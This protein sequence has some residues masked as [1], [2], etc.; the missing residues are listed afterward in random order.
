[1]S[2]APASGVYVIEVCLCE[3]A[4]ISVGRLGALRFPAGAYLYVGSGL[5]GL[6][7]RIRRHARRRKRLRWHIDYVTARGRVTRVWVW[8][9]D[10]ALEC[11][12]A[13]ALGERLA[14]VAGFGASD[15]RCIG[16]LFRRDHRDGVEALPEWDEVVWSHSSIGATPE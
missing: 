3:E 12:I 16:H 14:V 7:A 10:K 6:R 15:C 4:R 11:R 5:R 13:R 2:G 8:P 9:P 1:M